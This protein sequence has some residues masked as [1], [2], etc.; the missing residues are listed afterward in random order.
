MIAHFGQALEGIDPNPGRK[1]PV[2]LLN[3][4]IEALL[5]RSSIVAEHFV[6]L[7]PE[8]LVGAMMPV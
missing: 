3:Q 4:E 5:Q 6:Q 1:F 2:C 8:Y 7:K